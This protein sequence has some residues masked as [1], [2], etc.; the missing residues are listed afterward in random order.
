MKHTLSLSALS[1]LL[2]FAAAPGVMAQHQVKSRAAN[3]PPVIIK[4]S[5]HRM[6][7]IDFQARMSKDRSL[8]SEARTKGIDVAFTEWMQRDHPYLFKTECVK[9]AGEIA[10]EFKSTNHMEDFDVLIR[11]RADLRRLADKYGHDYAFEEWLRTERPDLYRQ[12]FNLGPDN[13][14]LKKIK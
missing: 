13:R 2:L 3:L 11:K 10:R 4:F 7:A 6:H 12:H 9:Q 1:M 8:A 14:P 5:A